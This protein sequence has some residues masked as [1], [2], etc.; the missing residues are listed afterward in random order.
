MEE[1]EILDEIEIR[2]Y[3]TLDEMLKENPNFIVFTVEELFGKFNQLLNDETKTK[4]FLKLHKSVI[5]HVEYPYYSEFTLPQLDLIRKPTDDISEYLEARERAYTA[6]NY[7]VQQQKVNEFSLPYTWEEGRNTF[8]FIPENGMIFVLNKNDKGKL[9]KTDK[10]EDLSFIGAQWVSPTYTVENYLSQEYKKTKAY[11]FVNW[12][13]AITDYNEWV[14][15]RVLPSLKDVIPKTIHTVTDV[16]TLKA[17]LFRYSYRLEDFTDEEFNLLKTHLE[18]I[19]DE[20]EEE[21]K[22]RVFKQGYIKLKS[23]D[24]WDA[25][26]ENNK[27]FLLYTNEQNLKSLE[28]KITGY[29]SSFQMIEKVELKDPLVPYILAEK[30]EINELSLNDVLKMIRTMNISVY[31]ALAEK[32]YLNIT[33][34][35]VPETEEIQRNKEIYQ[36]TYESYINERG[37][38]FIRRYIDFAEIKVGEDTSK[39]D[40]SPFA[41][42]ANLFEETM[43]PFLTV[44]NPEADRVIDNDIE[45]IYEIQMPEISEGTREIFESIVVDLIKIKNIS[46]LPLE[47]EELL[48][49]H[50]QYITRRSRVEEIK[51][52]LPEIPL[53]IAR[54][55]CTYNLENATEYIKEL[56]DE[57]LTENLLKIYP[58]IYAEWKKECKANMRI[59][60]TIWWLNL[61]E[62][63]IDKQLNFSILRGVVEHIHLWSPYGQPVEDNKDAGI[64][65]Y[66]SMIA[67]EVTGSGVEGIRRDMLNTGNTLLEDKVK[68]LKEKWS[69]YKKPK[70][71]SKRIR[72][73]IAETIRAIKA[74]ESVNVLGNY[75]ESYMYLPTLLPNSTVKKLGTWGHGCCLVTIGDSY[76]ADIEWKDELK[77]LWRLKELL[78]KDRWLIQKRKVYRM[79]KTEKE[80]EKQEGP[81]YVEKVLQIEEKEHKFVANDTWL[82]ESHISKLTP[83]HPGSVYVNDLLN[84]TLDRLY[85]TLSTKK[86]DAIKKA[87]KEIK[88]D[89]AIYNI[90]AFV[91][92]NLQKN[93]ENS[94]IY[95]DTIKDIKRV[96][97][98]EKNMK[99]PI[100]Q[101]AL[102]TVLALP[103]R[104]NNAKNF[105]LPEG[106]SSTIMERINS[107][108]YEYIIEYVKSTGMMTVKEIQDYITKMREDEKNA[109]LTYQD[110][111]TNDDRKLLKDLKKFGLKMDMPF[112][113]VTGDL[114]QEGQEHEAEDADFAQ[115]P[116]DY[117]RDDEV[118][119]D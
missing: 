85:G 3:I 89:T 60:L 46:G 4:T 119:D 43:N 1:E 73:V 106:I 11:K 57:K 50:K 103:G 55:I 92:T 51:I 9:L 13:D 66:L 52:K 118:L 74:K 39:Y 34:F 70:D 102:S 61:L 117:D 49:V 12:Q 48:E 19:I 31:Q 114:T 23:A 69:N 72:D 36:K 98:L 107:A 99:H 87:V 96:L 15:K 58:P 116:T 91:A 8:N 62:A 65:Q 79:F 68:R 10:I 77:P 24:L 20:K 112:G 16:A 30:I 44:D 5:D 97:S 101:F 78:A 35:K 108:N 111:L 17:L 80:A 18:S 71:T 42:L 38:V 41:G 63:S 93:I 56:T 59:A 86:R 28:E 32:L 53:I 45:E 115:L 7:S 109:K 29:I 40:G 82:L 81:V 37:S 6:I 47:I 84:A 22:N 14:K 21:K 54:K 25:I 33:A 105:I 88:T 90:I 113:V 26:K 110:E 95:L 94:Q 64:L 67:S 2:E 75:L 83:D 104:I 76:D 100:F 27:R